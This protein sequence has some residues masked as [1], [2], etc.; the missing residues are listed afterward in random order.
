MYFIYMPYEKNDRGECGCKTYSDSVKTAWSD[1]S[2][3]IDEAYIADSH[4]RDQ[5]P[6]I[7]RFVTPNTIPTH[8]I[9]TLY[10]PILATVL[11]LIYLKFEHGSSLFRCTLTYSRLSN[12][13]TLLWYKANFKRDWCCCTYSLTIDCQRKNCWRRVCFLFQTKLRT[14]ERETDAETENDERSDV[15][16]VQSIK[17]T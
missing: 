9:Y 11:L 13:G 10:C 1:D 4:N 3:V 7:I 2:D 14:T 15:H 5:Q 12:H 8:I 16:E 6:R 17:L